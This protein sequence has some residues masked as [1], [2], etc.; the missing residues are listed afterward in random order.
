M[1]VFRGGF[2]NPLFGGSTFEVQLGP[3]S[4]ELKGLKRDAWEAD[5]WDVTMPKTV[6]RWAPTLGILAHLLRMVMEPKYYAE[7]IGIIWRLDA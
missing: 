7:V 1:L 6:P 4:V 3:P 5:G 2:N